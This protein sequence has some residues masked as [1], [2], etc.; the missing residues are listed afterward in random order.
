MIVRG[1][2]INDMISQSLAVL[3]KP[4]ISTF[5]EF[6][7]RGGEREAL[8]YVG[9]AAAISGVA[10]FVFGLFSG[11]T[12]ALVLGVFAFLIPIISF[13]ISA[14]IIHYVG[15]NQGG[16]GTKGEVFY[17]MALFMA[18]ILAIN[19][20]VSS[21]PLLNCLALPLT[22]A[23]GIYQIYLGYLGIRSS[24]NLD[25]N[26]AII[27]MVIAFVIQ[28]MIGFLLALVLGS[29]M[30]MIGIVPATVVPPISTPYLFAV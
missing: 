28:L 21:I 14:L 3:T 26:K 9:V 6:E 13:Y 27:T 1:V 12:A 4:G 25:Q 5:E 20:A 17:T 29:V 30:A 15:T 2:S 7:K 23:L 24:M 19:G 22:L 16:T 10:A 11:I 8:T 18:P